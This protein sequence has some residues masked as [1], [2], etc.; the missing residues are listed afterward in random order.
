M[1]RSRRN[2]ILLTFVQ[3]FVMLK[4]HWK[5]DIKCIKNFSSFELLSNVSDAKNSIFDSFTFLIVIALSV[6]EIAILKYIKRLWSTQKT[7][8][9]FITSLIDSF[10]DTFF[11]I[12]L[13]CS[14]E[15]TASTEYSHDK[16][17]ISDK[18]FLLSV[19]VVLRISDAIKHY[20][21]LLISAID[22]YSHT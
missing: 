10:F 21:S 19:L 9:D 11:I 17:K 2:F 6:L 7:S 16:F 15:M 4:I 5:S 1:S 12:I 3:F 22:I 18:Y 8:F 13:H 20:M 14:I